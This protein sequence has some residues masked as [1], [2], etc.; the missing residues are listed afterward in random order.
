MGA[1]LITCCN[2]CGGLLLARE[3]Q[4]TRTCPYCNKQIVMNR[5]KKIA[6][7][8]NSFSASELLRELKSKQQANARKP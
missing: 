1:V 3:A 8:E 5:A 6:Y 7:A 4:K 2:H